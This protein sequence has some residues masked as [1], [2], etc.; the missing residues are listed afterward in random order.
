MSPSP[1]IGDHNKSN[2][3]TNT[4]KIAGIEFEPAEITTAVNDGKTFLAKGRTLY[5]LRQ[6][7]GVYYA[8]PVY[9]ERGALP[10][11]SRGRFALLTAAAANKLIGF[12]LCL[13]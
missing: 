8:S 12:E 2:M 9:K 6:S 5:T 10:L 3:N 1:R 13:A 4:L 11:V 7:Q